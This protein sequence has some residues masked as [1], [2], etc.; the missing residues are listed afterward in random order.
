MWICDVRRQP[1]A[2]I[3]QTIIISSSFIDHII[4]IVILYKTHIIFILYS[5]T[6]YIHDNIMIIL[7]IEKRQTDFDNYNDERG[8]SSSSI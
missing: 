8:K 3:I 2:Y 6:K 5:S 7:L 4:I 1:D